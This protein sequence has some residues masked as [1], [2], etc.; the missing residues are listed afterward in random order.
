MMSTVGRRGCALA[1]TFWDVVSRVSV[2][3]TI[4]TTGSGGRRQL[5]PGGPR[6][7]GDGDPRRLRIAERP[8]EEPLLRV[9]DEQAGGTR[10]LR[11]RRLL[12]EEAVPALDER[13]EAAHG[14]EVV[15]RAAVAARD[16]A[17]P[18]AAGRRRGR[19]L[20]RLERQI[21]L[22][23]RDLPSPFDALHVQDERKREHL[24]PVAR[25]AQLVADVAD[26]RGVPGRA[27]G[28]RPAVAIRDPLE[29]A[30]VAAY[31]RQGRSPAAAASRSP[32]ASRP[33]TALAR[34]QSRLVLRRRRGTRAPARRRRV[35]LR[36]R[37]GSRAGVRSSQDFDV[38]SAWAFDAGTQPARVS[39]TSHIAKSKP[40]EQLERVVIRFAGRLGRRHAADRATASRARPRSSGT[41]SRRS[42]TFPPRSA[43]LQARCRAYRGS[44]C[45]S[46]TTTSSRPATSRTCSSR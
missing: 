31:A 29:R 40:V 46:R 34:P 3:S 33:S 38:A 30:Q 32:S 42:P 11:V 25:A 39:Y 20:E 2:S 24:R 22:H 1:T 17:R 26:G 19:V 10:G 27:G 28:A 4:S 9:G 18:E 41:T 12:R 43:R 21:A 15:P 37:C 16:Y 6:D 35:A 14:A 8:V 13:D 23:G 5:A 7:C 36:R 44:R 45:T